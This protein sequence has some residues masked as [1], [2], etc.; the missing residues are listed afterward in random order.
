MTNSPAWVFTYFAAASVGAVLVPISTRFTASE[1]RYALEQSDSA[2]LVMIDRFRRRDYVAVLQEIDPEIGQTLGS[3]SPNLPRL[4]WVACSGVGCKPSF[5]PLERLFVSDPEPHERAELHKRRQSVSPDDTLIILYSSGTTS[6]PKGIMLNHAFSLRNACFHDSR[7]G[8]TDE[9]RF[10]TAMPFFHIGGCGWG[11]LSCLMVGATLV[12]IEV[13]DPAAAIESI[14]R[15]RCTI[16]FGVDTMF[17]A[18]LEHPSLKEHDLKSLRAA[19]SLGPPHLLERIEREMGVQAAM[20]M[21][22]TTEGYGNLSLCSVEDPRE[23]RLNTMGRIFPGIEY[24]IEDPSAGEEQPLG[25]DG[26]ILVRATVMQGYYNMPEQ[27]ERAIDA[28]GWLHTGDI[29]HLDADG[30]LTFTGR[31]KDM[32]KVGG[33]NVAAPEVE[34]VILQHPK[35]L[36]VHVVGVPDPRLAEVPVACVELKPSEQ[37]SEDEIIAF[38][39]DRLASFKVPR[40]VVFRTQFP[41][42][43]S[44]KIQKFALRKAVTA[45]LGLDASANGLRRST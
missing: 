25:R 19:I 34:A 22:G 39:A 12:S 32:L 43:G 15:E 9:D 44:G 4:R 5:I 40:H 18:E 28:R 17:I 30:Y 16:Q 20:N 3:P 38:T 10:F 29:G 41:M 13:F 42:T 33:E 23:C 37:C 11:L 14:A 21:W 2:A 36:Q 8:L 27:T 24:R 35:V 26:E 6:F 31:I 7:L 1:I 45:E